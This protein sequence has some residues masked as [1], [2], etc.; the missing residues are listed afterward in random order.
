M[1]GFDGVEHVLRLDDPVTVL[2]HARCRALVERRVTGE[3]LQYVLGR[4]AFRSVELHVDRRVLIPRPETEVVAG[5]AIAAARAAGRHAVVADLGTGSGAIALAVAAE[6]WPN[7]EVWATDASPDAIDVARANLAGLGRRA[8]VVRV[9]AGDWFTA[10]P[11]E[12]QGRIDVVVT[13][14]PYVGIDEHLPPE[15]AD[16]EPPAALVAGLTGLEAI[17]RIVA[18]APAWLA[19]PGTLVVEIG[20]TQR[21]AVLALAHAAGFDRAEVRPDLAGRPRVLVAVKSA[22]R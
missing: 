11:A 22:A 21:D 8:A 3:P 2:G 5:E 12:L 10:L 17:E 19:R 6:C 7:V 15:V 20:E 1:S 13:N 4:W 18:E 14:P 16:W 9:A